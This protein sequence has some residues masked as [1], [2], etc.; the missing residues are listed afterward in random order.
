[1]KI[2]WYSNACVRIS[3]DN[4]ANILC[5]PWISE[6]AFLG[7]W[8]HWPPIDSSLEAEFLSEPC[9]GIYISHLHPD[10]YDPKFIA[11]FSKLRPEIP[12][13][14]AKFSHPWLYR[15]LKSIL[16]SE[17]PLIELPPLTDF[18][19]AEDLIM[20]VFSA[21]T[22]NPMIC[23]VSVACQVQPNARGIDSIAVFKSDGQIVVNANDAMGLTLVPKIAANIGSADLL[24][25]HYGGASPYPQCFSEILD[26]KLARDVVVESTCKMLIEA[27]DALG[28]KYVMP[29]AGQY[30]LGGR[31]VDLNS[32][33]ATIALD[34]A[35]EKLRTMTKRDVVSVMPGGDIN[36][37]TSS[38]SPDYA[39]PSDEIYE[40][41]M[42][43]ISKKKFPYEKGFEKAW[44]TWDRDLL[45]SASKVIMKSRGVKLPFSS[46]IVIG[47]GNNYVTINFE[48]HGLSS[49]VI[50]GNVP[51][52]ETVTEIVVPPA[53]LRNLSTRRSDYKGFTTMHW[54]QADV[55]S[56]FVWKRRGDFEPISHSF[57]NYFGT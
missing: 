24:M 49:N 3:S 33:R 57:L 41:Y 12:I 37:T 36:L 35:V 20:N 1:V 16:P 48:S 29:F 39:E 23:G 8:F 22:C 28:V 14:L 15:S 5:D 45:D 25:G 52:Y 11:K 51:R 40:E 53:L 44:K 4:G 54:N 43:Q 46:S 55:G 31:L 10:H 34:K 21:D 7:S 38:K 19:V 50:L 32:N 6:G 30:V 26:K 27:S 18:H 2:R 56:H 47:D 42:T 13:Y 17:T 9:D